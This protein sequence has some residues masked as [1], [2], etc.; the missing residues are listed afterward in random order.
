[1]LLQFTLI[2]EKIALGSRSFGLATAI[3]KNLLKSLLRFLDLIITNKLACKVMAPFPV[4][5][6]E[7]ADEVNVA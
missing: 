5:T 2:S 7:A 3:C 1:V 6:L 4:H